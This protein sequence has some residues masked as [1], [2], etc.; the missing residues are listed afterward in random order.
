MP[1]L[2]HDMLTYRG[3]KVLKK[4]SYW[5]RRNLDDIPPLPITRRPLT[6]VLSG[7]CGVTIYL[8]GKGI[9]GDEENYGPDDGTR[10]GLWNEFSFTDDFVDAEDNITFSSTHLGC[11][12]IELDR[13]APL[14]P[15]GEKFRRTVPLGV[16]HYRSFYATHIMVCI[17]HLLDRKTDLVF[18]M[19][20][21]VFSFEPSSWR[22]D[23]REEFSGRPQ[24]VDFTVCLSFCLLLRF[25]PS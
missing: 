18:S 3:A 17:A 6:A 5:K 22:F 19:K 16:F 10:L 24:V 7:G 2:W 12:L 20:D 14:L 11:G 15:E 4:S 8:R 25:E 21:F 23:V 1:W 13:Y 9:H